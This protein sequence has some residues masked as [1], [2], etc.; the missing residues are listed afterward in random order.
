MT[1]EQK[2][3]TAAALVADANGKPWQWQTAYG[4]WK[5][6]ISI[7]ERLAFGRVLRPAPEPEPPKPWDCPE[8]VP[9]PV[10]WLRGKSMGGELLIVSVNSERIATSLGH[11]VQ[12]GVEDK[13]EYYHF[14][15]CEYSTTRRAD[16]WHPCVKA[17]K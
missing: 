7:D 14:R 12:F 15:D 2:L 1:K 11:G 10:C 9:G 5:N 16:D 4:E 3:S 13:P 8:D 17:P 6:G